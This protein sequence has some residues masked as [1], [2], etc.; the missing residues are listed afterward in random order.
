[1]IWKKYH[2]V[3]L[4][5]VL[6][7]ATLT[8][9]MISETGDGVSMLK[10]ELI[11]KDEYPEY[12]EDS[13]NWISLTKFIQNLGWRKH[14]SGI[15]TARLVMKMKNELM[16]IDGEEICWCYRSSSNET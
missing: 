12:I 14:W 2:C 4:N 16:M 1:M 3:I 9:F 11:H 15:K 13:E 10:S 7:S 6:Q 5:D 8:E